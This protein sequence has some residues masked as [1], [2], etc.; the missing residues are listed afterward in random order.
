VTFAL[1]I[2][3][4]CIAGTLTTVALGL[5]L[6][7]GVVD[8]LTFIVCAMPVAWG[9]AAVWVASDP[10]RLRPVLALSVVAALSYLSI[11][12]SSPL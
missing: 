8:R 12:A 10:R 2:P 4:A 7:W 3:F 5:R 6:P 9:V 1:V 11:Q